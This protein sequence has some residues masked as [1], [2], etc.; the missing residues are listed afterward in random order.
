MPPL[1]R[2]RLSLMMFLQYFMFGIWLV[3]LGTYMSQ[4]LRFDAI[5]GTAYGMQG[6]ATIFSTLLV[7]ALADRV[8]PAQRLLAVL[9]LLSAASLLLLAG[10]RSSPTL[11]LA[12]VGLQFLCFVP[13]ISLTS[14]IALHC[15]SDPA[16]QFPGIRV[17]GTV[18]WIVA[19]VVIGSIPGAGNSVLPLQIAAGVGLLF[20][21]YALTLPAVPPA[22]GG[23]AA[24][25]GAGGG[26]VRWADLLG[27]EMFARLR[28][29]EFAIFVAAVLAVMVPLGFYNTYTNNFLFE[30]G[31]SFE[32]FGRRFEPAAVQ[33]LGQVSELAF[34][35]VLP[36]FLR[37][38][39]V[40]GV[41][42]IGMLAWAVRYICFALA[43]G[44]S[45]LQFALIVAGV[46]LHG[47]CYD[48]F[49]VA[50][51]IYVDGKF[52]AA[53]RG[54]AQAFLVFINMGVGVILAS[55]FANAIYRANTSTAGVH[56]W[57]AIWLVP[58]GVAAAAALAFA[59]LFRLQRPVSDRVA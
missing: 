10:T 31:A 35:L 16:A 49:F 12:A 33:T 1:L 11:F 32:A 44:G 19:G 36:L 34:L 41:L 56:D 2:L 58:A 3:T 22:G 57:Q 51:Q 14:T 9:V 52:D 28:E 37:H 23:A 59:W 40:K 39:G 42:L 5:I 26:R 38:V 27:I 18:G 7:G 30:A 46:L 53:T 50:G 6:F 24:G 54:R 47:V 13:T 20:A 8:L 29:R 15:V 17:W 45:E 4:S 21:L 43:A 55:A 48:F 25:G